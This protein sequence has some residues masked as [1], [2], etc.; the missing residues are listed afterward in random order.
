M[1]CSQR[2]YEAITVIAS[3]GLPVQLATRVLGVSESGYYEWR[4]RAPSVRAVRHAWPTGQIQAVR[5]ASRHLRLPPGALWVSDITEHP[6]REGKVYCAV[7]LDACTRRVVGWSIDS[8]QTAALVT[9][10]LHGHSQPHRRPGRGDP[11]RPRTAIHLM[12]P[13]ETGPT[14]AGCCPRWGRSGLLRQRNDRIVLGLGPERTAQPAT[15]EN[16]SR[17]SQRPV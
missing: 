9:S 8:S 17:A 3:Q 16:P 7:V 14:P 4:G 5:L 10:A 1:W 2:R 6:T 15:L 13:L 12:G 11:L